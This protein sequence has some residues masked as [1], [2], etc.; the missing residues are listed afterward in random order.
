M[1]TIAEERP[2]KSREEVKTQIS[3]CNLVGG[4]IMILGIL[5]SLVVIISDAL[6]INVFLESSN[7]LLLA[8]LFV[9]G[10]IMPNLHSIMTK[11]LY[12]IES[13]IKK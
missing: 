2:F 10:S 9:I 6:D 5:F 3:K 12:G 8:I 7:W 13:E 1:I 4:I 11:H